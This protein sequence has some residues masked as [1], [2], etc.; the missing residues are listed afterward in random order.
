MGWRKR[1]SIVLGSLSGVG[2]LGVMGIRTLNYHPEA[3]EPLAPECVRPGRVLKP[4]DRFSVLSWNLQFSGSREE[5]FFYDGGQAVS[6]PEERVRRTM[7]GIEQVIREHSPDLVFLQEVDRDSRRTARID[8]LKH[9][10]E[11]GDW[12]CWS[13]TP[14]HRSRYVPHPSSEHLGRIDLHLAVL[15][16]LALEAGERIALPGLSEGWLR[17]QFNLKRAVQSLGLRV[18][19]RPSVRIGNTHLSAFSRG[20]GTLGH[21]VGVLQGWIGQGDSWILAGDMNMLPPGDDPARLEDSESSYSDDPNPVLGL[22]PERY[23]VDRADLLSPN[24]RTYLPFGAD[25]PDRKIDYLLASEDLELVEHR[26]LREA[27]ELSDH[28]PIWAVFEIRP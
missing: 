12:A 20:D 26:V 15:S 14:Y 24:A 22:Q 4:G 18:E 23:D 7:S 6:V 16:K 2:V 3:R 27:R 1:L 25:E 11:S 5:A 21:Q 9:Y 13:S 8:Q 10:L 19:G 17:K 28:L